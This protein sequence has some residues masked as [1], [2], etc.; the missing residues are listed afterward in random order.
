[1]PIDPLQAAIRAPKL[2]LNDSQWEKLQSLANDGESTVVADPPAG[3]SPRLTSN[4]LVATDRTGCEYLTLLGAMRL[5]Q[6]R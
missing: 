5:S 1:M 3:H 2:R 6:G 4:G